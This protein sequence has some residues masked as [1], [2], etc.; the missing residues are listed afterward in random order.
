MRVISGTAKGRTLKSPGAATRPIT[1]RVKENLFNIVGARVREA[2]VLDLFAG[3]GSV[4]IEALS[5]GARFAT[6]VENDRE[7]LRTLRDNLELTRLDARARIVRDDV[8][9]FIRHWT[10]DAGLYDFLYIAPPQY[11]ELWAET[12][13]ALDGRGMLAASGIIVAQIFPKEYRALELK[14]FAL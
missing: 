6:F 5:R 2:N 9:R 1:D 12:L 7:A 3:A 11:K 4:G 13:R 14:E 8:F 10:P